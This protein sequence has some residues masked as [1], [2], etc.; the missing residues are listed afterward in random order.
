MK[1]YNIEDL[2]EIDP[3]VQGADGWIVVVEQLTSNLTGNEMARK[4]Y[5]V[6][7]ESEANDN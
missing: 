1:Q 4:R 3:L 7:K 5:F 2:K 6:T